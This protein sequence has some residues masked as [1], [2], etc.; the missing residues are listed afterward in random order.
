V[1]TTR[2]TR[3]VEVPF[4]T[5][6]REDATALTGTST[7]V[8]AGKP[9]VVEETVETVTADGAVER[10]TVLSSRTLSEPVTRVVVVG[11]KPRPA[12]APRQPRPVAAPAR[13][14][15]AA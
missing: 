13:P 1:A 9:G 10:S 2:G 7:T 3:D 15:A 11:T 4:G 14:P 12:P 8:Q 6:R 5:E